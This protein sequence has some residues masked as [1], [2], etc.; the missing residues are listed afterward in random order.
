M[1]DK[2][3]V[4][5]YRFVKIPTRLAWCDAVPGSDAVDYILLSVSSAGVPGAFM[6]YYYQHYWRLCRCSD[7]APQVYIEGARAYRQN[8]LVYG[9]P[10]FQTHGDLAFWYC[11]LQR[12]WVLTPSA[13]VG[14]ALPQF[15]DDTGAATW[16]YLDDPHSVSADPRLRHYR[17]GA[18]AFVAFNEYGSTKSGEI[19]IPQIASRYQADASAFTPVGEYVNDEGDVVAQ[20]GAPKLQLETAD[21]DLVESIGSAVV[22]LHPVGEASYE[23]E[24]GDFRISYAVS[25]QYPDKPLLASGHGHTWRGKWP[26]T[27][28]SALQNLEP[29]QSGAPALSLAMDGLDPDSFADAAFPHKYIVGDARIWH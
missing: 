9:R 1:A 3:L 7:C 18:L 22:P 12:D 24:S 15:V 4:P 13:M 5:A 23:S 11:P 8:S 19:K 2:P 10:W 20:I 28:D 27:G 17:I 6:V 16:W 25:D 14:A 29:L 26:K 21:D